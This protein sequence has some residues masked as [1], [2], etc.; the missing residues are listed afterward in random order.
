ML[1]TA[2]DRLSTFTGRHIPHTLRLV[3]TCGHGCFSV[4]VGSIRGRCAGAGGE[5]V[6][7]AVGLGCFAWE[8]SRQRGIVYASPMC[9]RG[10]QKWLLLGIVTVLVG[11]SSDSSG[12]SAVPSSD[13][14]NSE[15]NEV[16][17]AP[18]N[19]DEGEGESVGGPD[20]GTQDSDEPINTG[21]AP[22]PGGSISDPDS[23]DEA[24]ALDDDEPEADPT[25]GGELPDPDAIDC[26]QDGDGTTTLVFVNGCAGSLSVQGSELDEQSIEPGEYVCVDIGSAA[27]TL[28]SKRYW[29]FVGDDPGPERHTL[30][31]FTFNTD[32]NDFDW[33]NISHVDAHNLPMQIVPVARPDCEWL[34]CEQSWLDSCPD[35][36]KTL[37]DSG[38][39]VSCV[40]PERDNPDSPVV[41]FFESCDDAYAWSADD[42]QG[43]DPSP[44]RAC[45]GEDWDIV[46][47]PSA[48]P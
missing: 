26:R 1:K 12:E 10:K 45:A 7:L 6:Q 42:Q 41:Q 8:A 15:S 25:T 27:E 38:Q 44:M 32:F 48:E 18:E 24:P 19:P 5:N 13:S 29:G 22:S 35:E 33:Y 36:G 28:S 37:D 16:N 20:D 40:S 31:E 30:A 23:A 17:G 39:V 11:C 43:D 46:F 9:V 34:T 47:C 3:K 2:A 4:A 14:P 21:G